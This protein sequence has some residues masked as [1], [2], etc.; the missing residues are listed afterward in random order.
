MDLGGDTIARVKGV[1]STFSCIKLCTEDSSCQ[2]IVW[3]TRTEMCLLK[4]AYPEHLTKTTW[5]AMPDGGAGV[6]VFMNCMEAA[7]IA[8]AT[9]QEVEQRKMEEGVAKEVNKLNETNSTVK[10]YPERVKMDEDLGKTENFEDGVT[11]F[12]KD[13]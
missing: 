6:V 2:A 12:F 5:V 7:N 10:P 8:M 11:K 4:G 3:I 13:S 9:I 1:T